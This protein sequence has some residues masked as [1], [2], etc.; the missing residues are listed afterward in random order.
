MTIYDHVEILR[1]ADGLYSGN[2]EPGGSVNLVRKRPTAFSQFS[3]TQSIGKSIE[4][5]ASGR[6]TERL[7]RTFGYTYNHSRNVATASGSTTATALSLTPK[8]LG[9]AFLSYR[10]PGALENLRVGVSR[11]RVRATSRKLILTSPSRVLRC[12]TPLPTTG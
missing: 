9:K 10:M 3:V 12:T 2:G 8:H 7:E 5:E 4:F 6:I 11:P 1:G